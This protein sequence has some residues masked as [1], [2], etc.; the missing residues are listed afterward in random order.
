VEGSVWQARVVEY[1]VQWNS[2]RRRQVDVNESEKTVS[3]NGHRFIMNSEN[4]DSGIEGR[5]LVHEPQTL[6][7]SNT[8]YLFIIPENHIPLMLDIEPRDEAFHSFERQHEI[9]ITYAAGEH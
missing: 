3:Q 7:K 2:E 9:Q 1:P 8:G 4:G 6:P 5:V